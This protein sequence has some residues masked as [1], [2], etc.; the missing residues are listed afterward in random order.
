MVRKWLDF[1]EE[2]R[3][4]RATWPERDAALLAFMATGATSSTAGRPRAA[5]CSTASSTSTR[6]SPCRKPG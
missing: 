3:L 5:S 4:R 1:V 6:A 2:R